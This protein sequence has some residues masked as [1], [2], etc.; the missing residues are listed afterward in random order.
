MDT[1]FAKAQ[2]KMENN[3]LFAPCCRYAAL[4]CRLYQGAC[5]Q[6]TPRF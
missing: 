5:I 1:I 3:S 6:C 2:E 4:L